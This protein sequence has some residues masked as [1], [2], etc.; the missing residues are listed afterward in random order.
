MTDELRIMIAAGGTG[1]HIYPAIAIADA[2]REE[3]PNARILFVG[4][5]ER[6]EW[7]AVPAAGYEIAPI[8]VSGWHRRVTVKNLLFPLKLIVSLWQSHRLIRNFSPHAVV[9]CGGFVAGPVGWMAAKGSVPLFL[10]EQNSFPGFTNRK[11]S[12]RAEQI[13]I[14]FENAARWFPEDKTVLAGNP[15]RKDLIEKLEDPAFPDKARKHFDLDATRPVLLVM[16]GSGG[17]KS[18]NEAM[19]QHLSALHDTEGIQVI[20][21]CGNSYLD[22]IGEKLGKGKDDTAKGKDNS[23]KGKDNSG[24]GK[25]DT[26]KGKDDT[27]KGKN[28]SGKETGWSERYPGLRLYGFMEDITEAW[29]VADVI[30]SR[31]GAI[32]CAELLAT[33]KAGILVPSPWVAGDHQT[34]NA[35]ALADRGAAILLRDKELPE[36]LP[37]A[38]RLLIRDESRRNAMQNRARKLAK[39]ESA[40]LIARQILDHVQQK[41]G[42]LPCNGIRRS[43]NDKTTGVT[44]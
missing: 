14:A 29:A 32:T 21:Q 23:G 43:V 1:G 44:K 39:K 38:I 10:Q 25:D 33:G 2:M 6:I 8:C 3:H 7:K 17:A 36:Q 19:L 30:V 11:L 26:G 15:V 37:E 27:A 13:F 34:H 16:G 9:S 20:W 41:A 28:D 35:K 18:I 40:T 22:A 31:A 4:T 12:A 5:R 24:K 42:S